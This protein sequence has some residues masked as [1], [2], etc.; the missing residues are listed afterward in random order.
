MKTIDKSLIYNNFRHRYKN[1]LL[2]TDEEKQTVLSW[3]NHENVRKW[4]YNAEAIP[5]QNHLRFIETL[6]NR[7]D[8]HYWLTYKDQQPYGVVSITDIDTSHSSAE[9]GLYRNPQI[10][11][12]GGGLDFYWTYYDFLFFQLNFDILKAG[13]VS[14]NAI[15]ILLNSFLGFRKTGLKVLSASREERLFYTATC[16]KRDVE[17][18]WQKKNNLREMLVYYKSTTFAEWKDKLC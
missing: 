4:M 13:M 7:E 9:V 17:I 18:G 6:K 16:L 2:L 5:M 10:Q 8:C 15:A 12:N 1:F 11:D 3:R 14:D